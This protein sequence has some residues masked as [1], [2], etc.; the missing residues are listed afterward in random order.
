M[1]LSNILFELFLT[2][3]L[4]FVQSFLQLLIHAHELYYHATPTDH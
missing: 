4:L 1:H 3:I 2:D